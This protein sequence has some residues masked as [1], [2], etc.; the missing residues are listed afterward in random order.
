VSTEN[1]TSNDPAEVGVVAKL[2]TLDRFL[3]VLSTDHHLAH[4]AEALAERFAGVFSPETSRPAW[5]NPASCS[6]PPRRSR[7]T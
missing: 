7:T 2:S 5:W 1:L 6:P 3:P 4:T